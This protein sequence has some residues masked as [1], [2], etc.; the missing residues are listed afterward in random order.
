M[1]PKRAQYGFTLIELLIV[2]AIIGI[3]SAIVLVSLSDSRRDARNA[4]VISQMY[5]YQKALNLYFAE[6]GRFP[7]PSGFAPGNRALYVC[8][9]SGRTPGVSCLPGASGSIVSEVETF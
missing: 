2:I 4:Q 9:G 3:L 5:E 6:T 1:Y 8:I 7:A